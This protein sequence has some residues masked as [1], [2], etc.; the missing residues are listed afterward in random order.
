M[1]IIA[2]Y[3]LIDPDNRDQ[4]LAAH[5]DLVARARKAPGCLDL[6]I[7]PDPLDP[8]RINNFELWADE[9]SL[10][11]WRSVA[12]APQIGT[13]IIGGHM[14]KYVIGDTLPVF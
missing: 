1:L 7:S 11:A 13:Q 6:S 10:A 8:G 3:M 2:G 14:A 9:E 4:V 5:H 12:E